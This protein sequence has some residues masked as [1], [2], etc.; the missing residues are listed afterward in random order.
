MHRRLF[1]PVFAR[2]LALVPTLFALAAATPAARAVNDGLTVVHVF[3]HLGSEPLSSLVADSDGWLYGTTY[4]DGAGLYGTIFKL[5]TDG[6]GL[7]VLHNFSNYL[8]ATVTPDGQL[9]EGA[10]IVGLDGF[11]YGT[12]DQGGSN[13]VGT[14][15]RLA[16]DGSAFQIL[17]T[18]SSTPGNGSRAFVGLV[19]GPDGTLYGGTYFGGSAGKG[20]VFSIQPDGSGFNL[21]HSFDGGAEG[22]VIIGT[23]ALS[24][25]GWLYGTANQGGD[26]SGSGTVFRLRTDGS[27]FA[28]LHTFNGS[29]GSNP[30]S[31]ILLHPDGQLFGVTYGGGSSGYGT[32]F[33]LAADGS[34]FTTL[35]TFG[36]APDAGGYLTGDLIAGA[37]GDVYGTV[38]QGGAFS[39]GS[40]FKIHPDGSGYTLIREFTGGDHDGWDPVGG[41]IQLPD[42]TLCGTTRFGGPTSA[43]AALGNG[44]VFSLRPDGSSPKTL[45]LLTGRAGEGGTPLDRAVPGPG[46]DLYGVNF[47]DGVYAH[48]TL[49]RLTPATGTVTVL[50]D[51]GASGSDGT[52][53]DAAP[54]PGA[55]GFLYGTTSTGGTSGSGTVYRVAPDGSGYSVLHAFGAAGDGTRP[56]GSLVQTADGSLFGVTESGGASAFGTVFRLSPDGSGYATLYSFNPYNGPDGS[57]PLAGLLV[58]AD[59]ALYGTASEGVASLGVVFRLQPDGSGYTVLHAFDGLASDEYPRAALIQAPDGTLYGTT[60]GY[61][62]GAYGVSAPGGVFKLSPDGSGY[63]VLHTFAGTPTEAAFSAAPLVLASDGL[64]YGAAAGGSTS[65]GP[66]GNGTLFRLATDGSGYAVFHAFSAAEG[67]LPTGL[68][69]AADGSLY[70]LIGAASQ[71]LGYL[72]RLSLSNHPPVPLG[73]SLTVPGDT[74]SPITLAATDA[75]GDPLTFTITTS[76]THGQLIGTAPDLVY[77]PDPGYAGPDEIRFYVSD[78]TA[79]AGPALITLS[80]VAP[81]TPQPPS[82][83]RHPASRSASVGDTVV[84]NVAATGTPTL[85]YQ[86]RHGGQPIPGATQPALVLSPTQAS[87]LGLYDVVVTN[88]QGFAVSDPATLTLTETFYSW[89]TARGL[90]YF[91]YDYYIY[92]PD[93]YSDPDGDGRSNLLEYAF[94]TDPFT[95]DAAP[96]PVLDP[97]AGTL[98]ATV[99]ST[100]TDATVTVEISTNLVNWS[101]LAATPAIESTQG[102][103]QTL[104]YA[105]P[106]GYPRLFA[107]YKITSAAY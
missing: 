103:Q 37:D 91:D 54:L 97:A 49:Y 55:D 14:I 74:A 46:G 36:S 47:S 1:L 16:R 29:D 99:S 72:Y 78:G 25:D 82:I 101:D 24:A 106:A 42:G 19:Q 60:Y 59:G 32:L 96:A 70:G 40:V 65:S 63:A 4:D 43:G 8:P 9:P 77:A 53:P 50:H 76:P 21:L 81:T 48:G 45:A 94:G 3:Q 23:L 104:L 71:N 38:E 61:F 7:T 66:L 28:V 15:F 18:F 86:W 2:R 62:S 5:R 95:P 90:G 17:H 79:T 41:L 68:V 10:L 58:G 30:R 100:A 31:R 87:D 107:R 22:S 39:R 88:T 105:L 52:A 84:F 83:L 26:A 67:Y 51:F 27:G 20:V 44:T 75:D 34:G 12:T 35:H 93:P 92:Y 80:I 56:R 13:H 73:Q 57:R 98:R 6:S 89:S 11:L 64:L 33:R 69:E 102:S 85:T